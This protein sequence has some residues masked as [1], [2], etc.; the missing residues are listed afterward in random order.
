MSLIFSTYFRLWLPVLVL[1][2][3]ASTPAAWTWAGSLLLVGPAW[4]I[5]SLVR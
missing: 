4:L 1:L 2:L 3:I 5:Y